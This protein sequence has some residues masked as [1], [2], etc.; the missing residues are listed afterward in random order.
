MTAR[1]EEAVE[2]AAAA[3]DRMVVDGVLTGA[4]VAA[5]DG[6][7]V[8]ADRAVGA[9][10][11][12]RA[13][14][15]DDRFLTTSITKAITAL[16]VMLLVDRGLLD[17]R[18]RV[19][20]HLPAFAG[21]GKEAVQVWHLLS[22]SSGLSQ[23]ANVAEG[24]PTSLAA[25]ELEAYAIA[26]PLSRPPGEVEYCSPAFW[27]LAAILRARTGQDHVAHLRHAITGPLGLAA[28]ELDYCPGDPAP[29]DLVPAIAHRN[30]HLAEQVRRIAYP[31]GGVVA[32][33]RGLVRLG[34]ELVRS[35]RGPDGLLSPAAVGAMS[36]TWSTGTWPDGRRAVWGLGLEL[37]PPGELWGSPTLFHAGAS[38]VGL[39]IDLDRGVALSLLTADWYLPRTVHARVAD[40]FAGAV[41]RRRTA[42]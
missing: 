36:R 3:V 8:V 26:T 13:L 29:A 34:G 27:L 22:H 21:E 35:Q 31:A 40:A 37:A 7:G 5:T 18:S 24:P 32:T 19:D 2:A 11:D 15:T 23:R 9:T 39:W 42:A 16:Q 1:L 4:V 41:S 38:G 25:A 28:D 17:L 12:R 10:A 30:V 14:T 33:A 6:S 20:A